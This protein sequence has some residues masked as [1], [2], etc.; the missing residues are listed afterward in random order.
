VDAREKAGLR[1]EFEY[2][3]LGMDGMPFQ[4]FFCKIMEYRDKD[5][6]KVKPHGN[7]GDRKNDGYIP[8]KGVFF[9][10][11]APEAPQANAWKSF[12]KLRKDFEGLLKQW[13]NVKEFHFVFNDKFKG[14]HPDLDKE[15]QQLVSEHG[16]HSGSIIIPRTLERWLFELPEDQIFTILNAVTEPFA[17]TTFLE[18]QLV[19]EHIKSMPQRKEDEGTSLPD[20]EEKIRFNGL[21]RRQAHQLEAGSY[22]IGIL[23]DFLDS[24]QEYNLAKE[25][26]QKLR[27][28]YNE[29]RTTLDSQAD[30]KFSGADVF[31]EMT[32]RCIPDANLGVLGALHVIFAKYFEACDI[33]EEPI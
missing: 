2:L 10:V 14:T 6:I 17:R 18:L 32:D 19:I 5:F 4:E 12:D 3:I 33:F 15:L 23:D 13:Q 11:Y 20:W 9:Q 21:T 8:G 25:L 30:G 27:A 16:L 28:L 31:S 26:Q 22:D 7:I 24:D 29:V 1:K